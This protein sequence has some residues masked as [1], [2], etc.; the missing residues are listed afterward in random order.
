MSEHPPRVAGREAAWCRAGPIPAPAAAPAARALAK[1]QRRGRAG[2][3]W[4]TVRSLGALLPAAAVLAGFA[5]SSLAAPL[6]P[7]EARGKQIYFEGRSA[8]G[9]EIQAVV[10][11]AGVSVPAT[12]VPCANCHGYD[13]LGRPE[14]GVVPPNITWGYLTKSYGHRHP[15][16]REHPAFDPQ[17]VAAA[18]AEGLDPA[19]SV[20]GSMMP[21]YRMSESDLA[22]TVAYLKRLETDLD[23]GIFDTEIKI[24]SVLPT[25]GPLGPLGRA[26][27]ATLEAYFDAVN[28]RGG[29][30]GRKILFR[31]VEYAADADST[32]ANV[33]RLIEQEQVFAVVGAF[34]A[35]AEPELFPLFESH[36]VPLIGPFSL[37]AGHGELRGRRTFF[38]LSGLPDQ[39]RALVDYAALQLDLARPSV[40]VILPADE[41]YNDIGKAIERQGRAYG[42]L[43][44]TIVRMSGNLVETA[45]RIR[46]LKRAGVEAV[47]YFGP[48]RGLGAF[49]DAAEV[50]G[51]RPYL[52]ASGLIT[53]RAIFDVATGFGDR[54][55]LA[56]PAVPSDLRPE[57][58]LE[59]KMLQNEYGLAKQ[60]MATQISAFTAAK[61]LVEA[62]RRSGRALSRVNLLAALE[63]LHEFETGLTPPISFGPNRRVGALGAYIVSIDLENGTFR[64]EPLWMP[65]DGQTLA[66]APGRPSSVTSR[67]IE[68]D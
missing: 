35:G 8:S 32:M 13:G 33:R 41:T 68:G 43:A 67:V 11:A 42:W 45:W 59:F 26:A 36:K 25:Q 64:P 56:Y 5:F 51:W 29:I 44:P 63:G 9:S 15:D 6:T 49:T 38:L 14:G 40:A 16:G 39:A 27:K 4:S 24:G 52:F 62:L 2:L 22:A 50:E 21:R 48:A 23:P 53:G 7:L 18:I 57:G 60:H 31:V 34:T 54:L 55:F 58:L 30:Y 65:L 47:F 3:G 17:T 28:F 61:I 12:V 46:E 66:Q 1:K 37:F 10:G 19:G 20:L